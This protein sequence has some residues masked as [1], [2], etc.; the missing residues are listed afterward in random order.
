MNNPRKLT[1]ERIAEI[2]AFKNTNFSD[3]PELTE[4]ELK[5]MRPRYLEYFGAHIGQ[6]LPGENMVYWIMGNPVGN[7]QPG[8]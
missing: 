7:S 6:N 8:Y 1:P 4:E 2:K 3:C 5:K